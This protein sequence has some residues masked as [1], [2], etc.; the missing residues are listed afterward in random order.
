MTVSDPAC[1]CTVPV[2][3]GGATLGRYRH[4]CAFF[5]NPRE[6]YRVMFPF[7]KEGLARGDRTLQ[8]V[9]PA[10]RDDYRQQLR[11]AGVD[12]DAEERRGALEVLSV[13]DLYLRDGRFDVERM[14]AT[15]RQ[16]LSPGSEDSISRITGHAEWAGEQWPGIQGFLEYEARLNEVVPEGRD[17]V[18]CLYDLSKTSAALIVDVLRTHPLVILGGLLQENPFYL[19]VEQFLARLREREIEV[20]AEAGDR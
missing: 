6:E 1:G 15:V 14:L 7:I 4:I 10:L 11:A 5:R 3:L 18:V 17:T 20:A 16:N 12:V 2:E 13:R 8:I 9:E 19:P